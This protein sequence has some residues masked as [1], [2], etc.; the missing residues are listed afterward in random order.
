VTFKDQ[1]VDHELRFTI[2]VEPMSFNNNRIHA[3]AAYLDV[4]VYNPSTTDGWSQPFVQDAGIYLRNNGA[5]IPDLIK[6]WVES[7]EMQML[8]ESWAAD[9]YNE[10]QE[11]DKALAG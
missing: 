7:V 10:T 8:A 6:A 4:A 5:E 1:F 3:A 11:S 9:N 2:R